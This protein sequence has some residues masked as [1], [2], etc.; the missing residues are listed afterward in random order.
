MAGVPAG[1]DVV[2]GL[3]PSGA[4]RA[5]RPALRPAGL[6]HQ[7]RPISRGPAMQTGTTGRLGAPGRDVHPAIRSC[8]HAPSG[9][10]MRSTRTSIRAALSVREWLPCRS[11]CW[12]PDLDVKRGHGRWRSWQPARHSRPAAGARGNPCRTRQ[13]DPLRFSRGSDPLLRVCLGPSRHSRST[14]PRQHAAAGAPLTPAARTAPAQRL[15]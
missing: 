3:W 1:Q 7:Q 5:R 15:S 13:E 10:R 11:R 8:D 14:P 9:H 12:P 6:A 2:C 4:A